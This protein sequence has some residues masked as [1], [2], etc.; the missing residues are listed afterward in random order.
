M[1]IAVMGS[2]GVGGFVGGRLAHAGCDVR[3]VARGE[4][5]KV[6]RANGLVIERDGQDAIRIPNVR[7][8]EDPALLGP[9]D[10]VIIAVKLRDTE[11]AAAAVRPLVTP[12][13]AVLSLQNGVTK[14]D[15]LRREFGAQAVVGGVTY[16]A[17]R[18]ARPGVIGQTGAVQ[19]VVIG[20]YDGRPSPRVQSLHDWLTRAGI[21]AAISDDIRR[22]LWEKFVFLVGL[23]STTATMRVRL[24]AILG[25]AQTRAFL[26]D[27]MREVVAVG[28]ALGVALPS[29][30]AEQR[31]AFADT[32]PQDMTSS[33]HHDREAGRPL[34]IEWLAGAVATLGRAH[35]IP[36]PL[37]RAVWDILALH[38]AGR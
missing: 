18:I 17:T 37:C 4:H 26:L 11:A 3:F 9:V 29:D 32:M 7:A 5:L 8:A 28:R 6:M 22:T 1:R 25:N 34:E 38:A 27:L 21:D 2:G 19:R 36:T 20:E 13:T 16:V 31:L 33:L 14:D 23:S 10:L 15:I 35:A 24:G 12:A 30:Y